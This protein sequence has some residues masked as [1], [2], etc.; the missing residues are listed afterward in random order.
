M[1][2]HHHIWKCQELPASFAWRKHERWSPRCLPRLC[3][4]CGWGC[5][6]SA[7]TCCFHLP[8]SHVHKAVLPT[9]SA[10]QLL[11]CCSHYQTETLLKC[12]TVLYYIWHFDETLMNTVCNIAIVQTLTAIVMGHV[13]NIAY[14]NYEF[15]SSKYWKGNYSNDSMFN[16]KRSRKPTRISLGHTTVHGCNKEEEIKNKIKIFIKILDVKYYS[17]LLVTSLHY[18]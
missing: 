17:P 2:S 4:S 1:E 3:G 7:L 9:D 8:H 5:W 16:W 11:H 14:T 18:H 10:H 12:T 15:I 13:H 6:C